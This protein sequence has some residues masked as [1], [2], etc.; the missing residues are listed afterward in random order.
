MSNT[1]R[2]IKGTFDILPLPSSTGSA[3][4]DGVWTWQFVEQRFAEIVRLFGFKEIRTPILEPTELIARGIGQLTDIVTKE[5]FAFEREGVHYVLRPEVTAPVIR[6]YLQHHMSQQGGVQKLYYMGPCFRAE[7]PQKGRYRQFHQ[8]GCEL[9]GSDSVYA[10]VEVISAMM[11]VYASFN[12]PNTKLLINTLGDEESRPKYKEALQSYFKKYENDLSE[13]SKARLEKNPLRILDTKIEKEQALLPA[14]PKLIEYISSSSRDKYE[15]LKELLTAVGIAYVEDPLLVRG[16]DYYTET[17]F[18]LVSED[19]GSQSALGGGGR[20]DLLAQEIGSKKPVPAVGFACGIDRLLIALEA[21]KTAIPA[22]PTLDVF[23]VGL[24][25]KALVWALESAHKLRNEGLR[26]GF[27]LKGRSMKA[28]MKEA[29][30][31]KS[32]YVVI[33][34]DNELESERAIVKNME[35]SVQEEVQFSALIDYFTRSI[36]AG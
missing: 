31:Q 30:R 20:Y 5:M 8:F 21:A 36:V 1:I 23:I 14:A 11:Q 4:S 34:G 15:Q 28:Q 3:H 29:N 18:E 27:D 24:G 25:E 7:Q 10:D 26:V 16:L 17:A 32:Q 22:E 33:V 13:V 19:V 12:L 6:A 9:I 2:N 35:E